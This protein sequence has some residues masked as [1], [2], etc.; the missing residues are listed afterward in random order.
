MSKAIKEGTIQW[1]GLSFWRSSMRLEAA[2]VT[3]QLGVTGVELHSSGPQLR[4]LY[5]NTTDT[6]EPTQH[7][8]YLPKRKLDTAREK[9]SSHKCATAYSTTVS[10]MFPL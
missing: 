8:W 9:K 2:A 5:Q 3:Q 4:E 6:S 10:Q 7:L 1:G